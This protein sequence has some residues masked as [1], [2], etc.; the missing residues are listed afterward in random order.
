[1]AA[2]F[3]FALVVVVLHGQV[4]LVLDQSKWKSGEGFCLGMEMRHASHEHG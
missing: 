4:C 3:R 1:M 2:D